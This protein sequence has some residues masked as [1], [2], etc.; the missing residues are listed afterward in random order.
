[1][2]DSQFEYESAPGEMTGLILRWIL[3][4]EAIQQVNQHVPAIRLFAAFCLTAMKRAAIN[5]LVMP[6][7]HSANLYPLI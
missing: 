3:V 1:M 4:L 2:T 6:G 5:I 7:L